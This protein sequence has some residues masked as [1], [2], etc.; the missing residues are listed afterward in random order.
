MQKRQMLLFS[1][2]MPANIRC[3]AREIMHDPVTVQIDRTMPAATVSHTLYSIE[4]SRKI[5][6]LKD[7]L[8]HTRMESVLVFTRTKYRAQRIAQQLKNAGY[9]ATSL[10]SN[11]TQNQR[12]AAMEGFCNNSFKVLVATDIAARGIDVLSISHVINYDVP[13]STD[14]YIHRIGRTGRIGKIGSA[15]TFITDKDA[16]TVRALRHLLD[17]TTGYRTIPYETKECRQNRKPINPSPA[18][19]S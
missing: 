7:I 10:Q 8:E 3:L 13:G 9:R 14:D 17:S 6:L 12:Q 15:F 19:S 2:T 11:L 4:E 5:T 1:A 16:V 18:F